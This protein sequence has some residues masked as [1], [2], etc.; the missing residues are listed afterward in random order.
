MQM[1]SNHSNGY[2]AISP[3]TVF[4]GRSGGGGGA[5]RAPERETEMFSNKIFYN[6]GQSTR[7]KTKHSQAVRK[8]N[9]LDRRVKKQ[10]RRQPYV[11]LIH[12][13]M[14]FTR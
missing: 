1:K 8:Y 12:M 9:D 10:K 4:T 3:S 6:S 5:D 7:K 13:N 2:Y 11:K 14:N